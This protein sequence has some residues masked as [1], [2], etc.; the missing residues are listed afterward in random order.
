MDQLQHETEVRYLPFPLLAR[1]LKNYEKQLS[2]AVWEENQEWIAKLKDKIHYT[3]IQISL[4]EV[5]DIP[6]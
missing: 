3:K 1:Q 5:Y 4:G 2:D 6:F